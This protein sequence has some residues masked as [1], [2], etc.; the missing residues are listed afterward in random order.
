VFKRGNRHRILSG[1]NTA[2]RLGSE[3]SEQHMLSI[4]FLC[5]G[6]VSRVAASFFS[7]Y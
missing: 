7:S 4:D 5:R 6:L 2:E 3:D 1:G